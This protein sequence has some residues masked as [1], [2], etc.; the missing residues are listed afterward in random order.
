MRVKYEVTMKWLQQVGGDYYEPER[1]YDARLFH[2][3]LSSDYEPELTPSL[4]ENKLNLPPLP[5]EPQSVKS[6]ESV[7]ELKGG[8][9]PG[10]KYPSSFEEQILMVLENSDMVDSGRFES[11]MGSTLESLKLDDEDILRETLKYVI[12]RLVMNK[13]NEDYRDTPG[14]NRLASALFTLG[15]IVKMLGQRLEW[16]NLLRKDYRS[17]TE[18]NSLNFRADGPVA[19]KWQSWLKRIIGTIYSLLHPAV[20]PV[21][22]ELL[23]KEKPISLDKK[24]LS[25]IVYKAMPEISKWKAGEYGS[26]LEVLLTERMISSVSGFGLQYRYILRDIFEPIELPN[27]GPGP[28]ISYSTPPRFS[29]NVNTG[30]IATYTGYRKVDVDGQLYCQPIELCLC[31]EPVDSRGPRLEEFSVTVDT[32]SFSYRMDRFNPSKVPPWSIHF[33]ERSTKEKEKNPLWLFRESQYMIA[34]SITSAQADLLGVLWAHE[35]C[36]G[37]RNALLDRLKFAKSTYWKVLKPLLKNGMVTTLYHPELELSG[38]V[39]VQIFII[40]GST[41]QKVESAASWFLH[42][43]PCVHLQR[44][45]SSK[46]LIA[47][48]HLPLNSAGSYEGYLQHT[49]WKELE[50]EPI[51]LRVHTRSTYYLT[52]RG[53][54][55]DSSSLEWKNPWMK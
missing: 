53:R 30:T 13:V 22:K 3:M 1:L 14:L 29:R 15:S 6:I 52:L 45:G 16:R 44:S 2:D 12:G 50:I 27:I 26:E 28:F 35:G 23:N 31:V 34:R 42:V 7:I 47:I 5:K 54:L 9:I 18:W 25:K 4:F 46:N 17:Q 55:F 49:L 32:D 33:G 43:A 38:L 24:S 20:V 11:W 8:T 51:S 48:L 21:C 19:L 36:C 40:K 10:Y 37:S 39:E 41:P